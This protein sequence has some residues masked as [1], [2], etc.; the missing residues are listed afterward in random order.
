[1]GF[2]SRWFGD[3]VKVRF[4]GVAVDGRDFTGMVEIESFNNSKEEIERGLKQIFY[5]ETGV[6]VKELR[7]VAYI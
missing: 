3:C 1:M 6:S 7:I 5:V 4:E 2:L